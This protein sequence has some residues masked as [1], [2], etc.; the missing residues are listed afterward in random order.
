MCYFAE[1]LSTV[2]FV[3]PI[4]IQVYKKFRWCKFGSLALRVSYTYTA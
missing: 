4:L 3:Y 2:I 1:A